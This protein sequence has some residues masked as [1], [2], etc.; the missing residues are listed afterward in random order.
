MRFSADRS[1]ASNRTIPACNSRPRPSTL[2]I[3]ICWGQHEARAATSSSTRIFRRRA[4][5]RRQGRSVR[6][7]RRP[8]ATTIPPTS[9]S[10]SARGRFRGVNYVWRDQ[11]TYTLARLGLTLFNG[12]TPQ[13]VWGYLAG[14]YPTEALAYQGTAYVCAAELSIS[15]SSATSATTISRS[16]ARSP[17][18]A[19]TASTPT[20]RKSSTI[21]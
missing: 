18:R 11:S 9:S 4:Q 1:P 20:P 10:R 3:P 5:E 19:S 8:P 6:R 15:G 17:A 12:T 16:S 13:T 14:T 21:S 2:P 7:R